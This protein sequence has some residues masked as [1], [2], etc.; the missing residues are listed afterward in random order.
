MK[1]KSQT[2][3]YYRTMSPLRAGLLIAL[4]LSA[5]FRAA[6]AQQKLA[7]TGMKFLNVGTSARVTA[8][9]EAFTAVESASPAMFFNPAG[10][11]R[12]ESL[13]D[14][15]LGQTG[16]IA[17]IKHHHAGLAVSPLGGDYG[18][19][20]LMAMSVDYGEMEET[21]RWPNEQ[22]Y[23]DLGTFTPRALMIG[24]G[25]A[26]ALTEKFSVG[27]NVKFV[28]QNLGS[29]AI[30][31]DKNELIKKNNIAEVF[32][33]DFGMLYKTGLRSLNFGVS[34]RNFSREVRYERE[35][36][37]LP[38]IFRIG[39]SM[40]M[41]DLIAS[42]QTTHSL[43]LAVDATHPRDY[44]EQ[45][46]IGAEYVFM[47]MIAVRAGYMFNNDE[48][49]LTAGVGVQQGIS[50]LNLGADYSYTPFGIFDPVHRITVRFS[51]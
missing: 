5:L 1:M 33:F 48:Y 44:P 30:G 6:P 49:G 28:T 37:Q 45:I 15:A 34:V 19:I 31:F 2:F 8:M 47:N 50:E 13:V 17:D 38:L 35:G 18:V 3:N 10:M 16:W 21:V 26:K 36:F 32:A 40:N 7:Q 29:S 42:D 39:L 12:M 24:I 46:N 11:A 27:G 14:V 22:G 20:G 9:G 43:L 51:Y 25:Y 4:F 41:I 23:L